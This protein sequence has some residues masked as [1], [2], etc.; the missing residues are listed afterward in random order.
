ME[1]NSKQ[2]TPNWRAFLILGRIS[3]LPTVWSNCLVGWLMGGVV[4]W[5]VLAWLCL[6][7]TLLYVGGMYLNDAFDADFDRQFR[8]ERPI[9]AGHV[10]E[11]NVWLLGWGQMAVGA[12]CLVFGCDVSWIIVLLLVGSIILYDA[13]HKLVPFSPV[14]MA[15]CRFFLVLAAFDASGNP[16]Q[17]YALWTA[18]ALASYIV[19]L[20]YVAKRESTGGVISFW[21]CLLIAAPMLLS[22]LVNNGRFFWMGIGASVVLFLWILYCLQFVMFTRKIQIFKTVSGL[23]A[24]IALVDMVAIV[25]QHPYWLGI[26]FL[27]FV[28]ALL[29]QRFVPAT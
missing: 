18:F 8:K 7:G 16:W 13:I 6:G 20:T 4:G 17:G 12:V 2:Q 19:G 22:Y 9:P 10:K 5:D 28:S 14:I 27:L 1:S 15:A 3:N 21:P 29:F 24:G 25:G 23:L 11:K 26:M